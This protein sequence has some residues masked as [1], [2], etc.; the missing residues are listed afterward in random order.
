[1]HELHTTGEQVLKKL[2]F[3]SSTVRMFDAGGFDLNQLCPRETQ[4]DACPLA[5]SDDLP[6][7]Q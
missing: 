4:Y 3:Y 6:P 5:C 1:M 2:T 7:R